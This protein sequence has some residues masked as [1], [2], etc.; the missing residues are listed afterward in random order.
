MKNKE[1][2]I[3]TLKHKKAF[4]YV[5][6]KLLGYNTLRGYLH[7]LDKVILY[8]IF[9]Y[10]KV[11]NFHRKH[12]KHHNKAKKEKD[13]IQMVIDWESARYTKPDKPLTAYETLYAYYSNLEDQILPILKRFNLV[14]N[15]Q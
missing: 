8:L 11:H 2:I 3:Y 7:D 12:S 13:Y 4:L 1:K 5:E 6:K 14:E 10:K 9:D 15:K